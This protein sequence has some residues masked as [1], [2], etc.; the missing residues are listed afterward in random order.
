MIVDRLLPG[1]GGLT[2]VESLRK[3]QVRTRRSSC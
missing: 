2:I 3:E 1:M